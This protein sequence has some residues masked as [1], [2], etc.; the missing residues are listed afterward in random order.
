MARNKYKAKLKKMLRGESPETLAKLAPIVEDA[1]FLAGEL[2][3]VRLILEENG[4]SENYVNG[5]N[6]IGTMVSSTAKA[7]FQ[8]QKTYNADIRTILAVL[9]SEHNDAAGPR[10]TKNGLLALLDN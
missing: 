3:K 9:D 5:E 2:D 6:Q 8:M 10:P 7:Y 1:A 4:W